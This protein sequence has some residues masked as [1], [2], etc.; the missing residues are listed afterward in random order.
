MKLDLQTLAVI[1]LKEK[2][3]AKNQEAVFKESPSKAGGN[4]G[5]KKRI[6]RQIAPS[7]QNIHAVT[8]VS[9]SQYGESCAQ[10]KG[11][12]ENLVIQTNERKES[13]VYDVR[14]CG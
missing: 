6:L 1:A 2:A 12:M 9:L 4:K 14:G 10:E 11:W 5:T 7:I 3:I 8:R 13:L